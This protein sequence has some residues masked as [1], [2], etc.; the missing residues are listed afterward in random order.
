MEQLGISEARIEDAE[1]QPGV[2]LHLP[3]EITEIAGLEP[4]DEVL[5]KQVVVDD[6][7]TKMVLEFPD[8]DLTDEQ[9]TELQDALQ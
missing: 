4:G 8:L 9:K 7:D 1:D 3:D 2:D 5:V 6:T